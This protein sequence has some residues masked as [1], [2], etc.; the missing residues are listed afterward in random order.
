MTST[1]ATYWLIRKVIILAGMM[2][3]YHI[4][5]HP[6]LVGQLAG[7]QSLLPS[8]SGLLGHPAAAIRQVVG[9]S[10]RVSEPG[11]RPCRPSPRPGRYRSG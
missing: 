2:V 1:R 7:A 4:Y 9:S 3:A 6:W 10:G 5:I 8:G 11:N